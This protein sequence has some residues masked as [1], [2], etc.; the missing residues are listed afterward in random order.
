MLRGQT[1]PAR[2]R[3]I[4]LAAQEAGHLVGGDR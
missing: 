1:S 4:E 2:E 3:S